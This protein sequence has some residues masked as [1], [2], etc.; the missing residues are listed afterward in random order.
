[1]KRMKELE[2]NTKKTITGKE[3]YRRTNQ[4]FEK[5]SLTNKNKKTLQKCSLK[6]DELVTWKDKQ[7]FMK[8]RKK[9]LL[10]NS[11]GKSNNKK[12]QMTI[13]N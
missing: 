11:G 4:L 1:M 7:V 9:K 13:K 2:E 12:Q 10:P 6:V 3:N 8:I 5:S